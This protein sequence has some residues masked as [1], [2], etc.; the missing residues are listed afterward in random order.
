MSKRLDVN[1]A[2]NVIG[3]V[4]HGFY[5]FRGERLKDNYIKL[6]KLTKYLYGNAKNNMDD[7]FHV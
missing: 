2:V 7:F 5:I 6:Y 3:G 1:Y 4:L